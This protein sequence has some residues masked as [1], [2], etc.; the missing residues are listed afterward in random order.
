MSDPLRSQYVTRT[1]LCETLAG[2]RQDLLQITACG[3]REEV[4]A[5][6]RVVITARIHPGESNS[7]FIMKGVIDFLTNDESPE[8]HLLRSNFVYNLVPMINIDGVINGNYRTSLSGM[9]LNR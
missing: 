3:T 7:S 5:R 4:A 2:N 8:A 6:K 9:D 1:K